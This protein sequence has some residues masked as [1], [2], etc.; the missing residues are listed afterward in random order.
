MG[1]IIARRIVDTLG[2]LYERVYP[3]YPFC[4]DGNGYEND[5]HLC[6]REEVAE[7]KQQAKDSAGCAYGRLID[8]RGITLVE[9]PHGLC[10]TVAAIFVCSPE[11]QNAVE[12]LCAGEMLVPDEL[13][14]FHE[15]GVFL[16]VHKGIVKAGKLVGEHSHMTQGRAE[17]AH[18]VEEQ[19]ALCT[20]QIF[21][22]AAEHPQG[23]H[24]E[25][26]V[27]EGSLNIERAAVHEHMGEQLPPAEQG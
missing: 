9:Q 20:P 5:V 11:V 4:L 6:I 7:S 27:H 14:I 25:E 8:H 17:A 19:E 10:R 2:K 24:V 15:G 12:R 26:N 1:D 22:N 13:G 3:H 18:Q 16:V 23:I 21:E